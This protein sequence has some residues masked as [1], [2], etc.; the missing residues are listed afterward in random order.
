MKVSIITVVLNAEKTLGRTI[1]SVLAQTYDNIE[2][3]IIDGRSTDN[4]LKIAEE[5]RPAFE[6]RGYEYRIFS[7]SDHGIYDAMNKGIIRSTGELVGIINGDDWYEPDAV[8]K[9]AKKYDQE[10]YDLCFA[11]IRMHMRNGSTF[12]KKARVRR[13]T[14]S[15]DWN[16]PTQFVRRRVYDRFKYKCEN[17]SDDMDFYFKVKRSGMKICVINEVLANF[18]MGGVSSRIPLKEVWTRIMRRYR[19]YRNNGYSRLYIFECAAFEIIKYI[20]A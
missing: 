11:D 1:D 5:Y 3:I 18:T 12:I 7:E 17:I 13:Y 19:I 14:T 16:H 15:R 2:Y 9:M 6:E 8:E 4:T 20:L 10:H